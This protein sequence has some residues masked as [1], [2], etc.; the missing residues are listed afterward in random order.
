MKSIAECLADELINAAK[1]S[2]NSYAIKVRSCPLQIQFRSRL[3]LWTEKR[4]AR[5][6]GKVQSVNVYCFVVL[7]IQSFALCPI[8]FFV[9]SRNG[10]SLLHHPRSRHGFHRW[11]RHRSC[12]FSPV[13][14]DPGKFTAPTAVL[15]ICLCPPL[16]AEGRVAPVPCPPAGSNCRSEW[17]YQPALYHPVGSW[18]GAVRKLEDSVPLF[19]LPANFCLP[20]SSVIIEMVWR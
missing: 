9:L 15:G 16:D 8:H 17:P 18:D 20:M 4:R 14:P 12:P 1:G 10:E 7:H 19:A 5:A 2:S 11:G 13:L 6:C 3:L